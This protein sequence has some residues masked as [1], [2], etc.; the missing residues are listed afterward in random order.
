MRIG[1]RAIHTLFLLLL[2]LVVAVFALVG[3]FLTPLLVSL[4]AERKSL[5][6]RQ[7]T[8]RAVAWVRQRAEPPFFLWLHYYDPH[9][10]YRPPAPFEERFAGRLYDGEIAWTSWASQPMIITD[11][12]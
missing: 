2:P 1:A 10:A 11:G 9:A 8:D 12:R 7:L 6:T 4:G 5:D 3:G